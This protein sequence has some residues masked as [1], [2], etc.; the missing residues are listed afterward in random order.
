M[1]LF[2]GSLSSKAVIIGLIFV[3][4]NHPDLQKKLHS[5]IDY[6]EGT[7]SPTDRRHCPY[8]EATIIEILRNFPVILVTYPGNAV[9]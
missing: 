8:I 2:S 9:I 5:K 7:P 1:C 3:L 6:I 4:K